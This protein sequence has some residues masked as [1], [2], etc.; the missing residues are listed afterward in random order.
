MLRSAFPISVQGIKRATEHETVNI[1]AGKRRIPFQVHFIPCPY[2]E[3]PVMTFAYLASP[4]ATGRSPVFQDLDDGQKLWFRVLSVFEANLRKDIDEIPREADY[5]LVRLWGL[6]YLALAFDQKGWMVERRQVTLK[7]K[8][9]AKYTAIGMKKENDQRDRKPKVNLTLEKVHTGVEEYLGGSLAG[10][11][12]GVDA[13]QWA[14]YCE[15]ENRLLNKIFGITRACGAFKD[16]LEKIKDCCETI[17]KMAGDTGR[18]YLR[19]LQSCADSALG[20][21]YEFTSSAIFS[22]L[23]AMA[24][25]GTLHAKLTREDIA[26]NRYLHTPREELGG[27]VLALHPL[28][29]IILDSKKAITLL[30]AHALDTDDQDARARFNAILVIAAGI[31]DNILNEPG[32]DE[33]V[34]EAFYRD[35]DNPDTPLSLAVSPV[36]SP[37]VDVAR[38]EMREWILRTLEQDEELQR[39][40]PV[41]W[42]RVFLELPVSEVAKKYGISTGEVSKRTSAARK[43]LHMLAVKRGFSPSSD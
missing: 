18:I 2:V 1:S 41:F 10:G 14:G 37:D 24:A 40:K 29:S 34:A 22:E 30:Q 31:Y 11:L 28:G 13:E 4:P 39:Y 35:P 15:F 17:R 23:E 38:Q 12:G 43:R 42:D 27:L 9:G 36:D 33:E 6:A 5:Q 25:S 20:D 26:A 19:L 21:I 3:N 16:R 32:P 7:M 8:A